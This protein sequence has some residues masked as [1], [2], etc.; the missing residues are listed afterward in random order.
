MALA[1]LEASYTGKPADQKSV[2]VAK[3][4]CVSAA[5]ARLSKR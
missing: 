3:A 4:A 1:D 5:K 2:W